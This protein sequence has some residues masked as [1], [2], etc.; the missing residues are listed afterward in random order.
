[1]SEVSPHGFRV[2]VY[3]GEGL[4]LRAGGG[5]GA[6]LCKLT[7]TNHHEKVDMKLPEIGDSNSH[8]SRLA[9]HLFDDAVDTDQ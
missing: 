3:G 1:M 8:G 6:V 7:G 2:E 5:L 9:T 4:G